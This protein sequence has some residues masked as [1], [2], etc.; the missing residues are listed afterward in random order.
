[1]IDLLPSFGGFF[2]TILAFVGALSVIVAVHEY[3][4]YIV[5]R[6]C[7]IQAEVFSLGMGPVLWSKMDRH[8]TRWQLA[9][10]PV[11]GYVKFMGD[12]NAASGKD[13][14][15]MSELSDEERARTMHGAAIWRRS[16]TVL[17]GPVFNFILSI[18]IY[19]GVIL[20]MGSVSEQPTIGTLKELPEPITT[21]MPGDRFIEVGGQKTP[22]YASF[23]AA[24]EAQPV[25]P[26]RY[27]VEREGR[28]I[29]VSGPYPLLP[30]IDQ[31]QPLSAAY[32]AGL[33]AGDYILSINGTPIGGFVDL[34][35]AVL[36]SEGASLSLEVL[37]GGAGRFPAGEVVTIDLAP[38]KTAIPLSDGGFETRWLLGVSGGLF[39]EPATTRPGVVEAV[40]YGAV[41]TWDVI[42]ASIS[43]ISHMISGAISSCNLQGPIS[44]AKASGATAS[45]GALS[46]I[47]FIAL[48]S[49]AVGLLNL[50]PIPVLDG[51]HLV[52][53]LYEGIAGRPPSDRALQLMFTVGLALILTLMVFALSNDLFCP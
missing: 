21:L 20:T 52:F 50:F 12:A 41:R 30:I 19:A 43:G 25:G 38:T 33:A 3:G 14:E 28:D 49:T 1:M 22:D 42:T 17:A 44:I 35:N 15:Y 53:H 6:W 9:A 47:L 8:G 2:W 24:A 51:G 16:A 11:G 4:H 23:N 7:G 39:F 27:V 13:G 46:F 32:D 45:Q 29:E 37:A 10:F 31:V 48:L 36:A 18:L 5:G 34:Q 40:E 26:T